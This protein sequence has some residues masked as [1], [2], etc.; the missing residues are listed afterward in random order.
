[1]SNNKRIEDYRSPL[2]N[3]AIAAQRE[4]EKARGAA[5]HA[6]TREQESHQD[7]RAAILRLRDEE[8]EMLLRFDGGGYLIHHLVNTCDVPYQELQDFID[9][10]KRKQAIPC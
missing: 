3:K 1:V 8:P 5:S 2:F 10:I 4:H 6:A 9:E 7:F